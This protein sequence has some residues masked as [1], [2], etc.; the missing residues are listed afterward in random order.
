[1]KEIEQNRHLKKSSI[2]QQ[3]REFS[4]QNIDGNKTQHTWRKCHYHGFQ[5]P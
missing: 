1:M 2:L 5:K 4:V 3:K